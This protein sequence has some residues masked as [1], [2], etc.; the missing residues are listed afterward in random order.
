MTGPGRLFVSQ[1][2]PEF[3]VLATGSAHPQLEPRVSRLARVQIEELVPGDGRCRSA[4]AISSTP[5]R[6]APTA[7]TTGSP[8]RRSP[9]R[10]PAERSRL[11]RAFG[12]RWILAEEGEVYPDARAVTGVDGRGAPPRPARSSPDPARGAALGGPGLR[13]R[14][15]SGA[16]AL[17]RSDALRSRDATSSCP[18][19]GDEDGAA[20]SH[21]R[22]SDVAI[23][24]AAAS[25]RVAADG[26]G[27]VVFSR[28]YLPA[29]R[30]RSTDGMSRS[31]SPTR[32]TSRW[33]CRPE[34]TASSSA[35]IGGRSRAASRSR[36]PSFC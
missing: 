20:P 34:T 22:L 16:L 12:G 5:I 32:A 15:L 9:R 13:R 10:R 36:P 24:A 19:A 27:Y 4:R 7:T 26:P 1:R 21:A 18:G 17:L 31:S 11:L 35:G 3:N 29:W 6:T 25:A 28:T 14:S 33:P 23:G 30:R 2:L 8:G